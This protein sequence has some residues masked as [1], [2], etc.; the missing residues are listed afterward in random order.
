MR[1]GSWLGVTGLVMAAS[2]VMLATGLVWITA[3]NPLWLVETA[4]RLVAL[5]W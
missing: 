2:S 3:T 5:V 1:A 4:A